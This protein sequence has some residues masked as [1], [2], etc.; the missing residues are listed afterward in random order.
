MRVNKEYY[1]ADRY[2]RP[3]VVQRFV[4]WCSRQETAARRAKDRPSELIAKRMKS[5][6]L[7]NYKLIK[8]HSARLCKDWEEHPENMFSWIITQFPNGKCKL[9]R[10]DKAADFE[11]ANITLKP[12]D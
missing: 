7:K 6:C 11:P 8:G 10:H 1:S 3:E 4:A 5:I 9:V 2:D 12:L